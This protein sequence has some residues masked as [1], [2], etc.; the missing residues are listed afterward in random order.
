MLNRRI[1][2]R[3][4]DLGANTIF[5]PTWEIHARA[6]YTAELLGEDDRLHEVVFD[7]IHKDK[8]RLDNREALI[9]FFANHGVSK[10][11][12]EKTYDS[13]AVESMVR[14]ARVMQGRYG[15]RG[16]P[17][18][19]INGKYRTSASLAGGYD[20]MIRVIEALV[21]MEKKTL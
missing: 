6:Y 4:S 9:T 8:I 17:T 20:N 10:S 15:V 16:T 1:L 2:L 3:L 19:V 21:E 18:V 5:R 13:F 14:K 7:A 11:D 12:F